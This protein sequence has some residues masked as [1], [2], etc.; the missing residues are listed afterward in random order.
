MAAKIA[1]T[2]PMRYFGTPYEDCSPM[3]AFLASKRA[4]YINGEIITISGGGKVPL[5]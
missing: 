3:A 4:G 5:D 1:E 2:N